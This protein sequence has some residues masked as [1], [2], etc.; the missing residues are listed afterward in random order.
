MVGEWRRATDPEVVLL[1]KEGSGGDGSRVVSGS[2]GADPSESPFAFYAP[3]DLGTI[4]ARRRTALGLH[5]VGVGGDASA[6]QGLPADYSLVTK[7]VLFMPPLNFSMVSAGIYRGGYPKS[8]NY[9]FLR[10]LGLR[11]MLNLMHKEY[12]A[13][14][15]FLAIARALLLLLLR[16]ALCPSLVISAS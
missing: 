2:T 8:T 16:V 6:L 5:G 9:G 14:V 10:K 3:H 4:A 15:R 13:E 12:D 1:S 11:S 7:P